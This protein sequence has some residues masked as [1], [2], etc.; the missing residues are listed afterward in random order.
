MQK[1]NKKSFRLICGGNSLVGF[2]IEGAVIGAIGV[3]YEEYK[4]IERKKDQ[5]RCMV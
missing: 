5:G 3:L 2:A 4:D 1:I